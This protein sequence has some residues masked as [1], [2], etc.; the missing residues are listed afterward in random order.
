MGIYTDI[1]RVVG[2]PSV[3]SRT[4]Q[5][6]SHQMMSFRGGNATNDSNRRLLCRSD[7][8]PSVA[9]A[10][11]ELVKQN[12]VILFQCRLQERFTLRC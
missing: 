12:T 10:D 2:F 7:A 1:R 5:S 9:K 4:R 3:T 8:R 11:A 6:A